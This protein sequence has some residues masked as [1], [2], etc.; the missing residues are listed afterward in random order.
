L[1]LENHIGR[2]TIRPP[3]TD[4]A[5]NLKVLLEI[6]IFSWKIKFPAGNPDFQRN[7]ESS[8]GNLKIQLEINF[9]G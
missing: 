8:A 4:F 9:S 1:R 3:K 6:Q 5:G 7:A 2:S